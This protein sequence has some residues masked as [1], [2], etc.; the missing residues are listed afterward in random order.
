MKGFAWMQCI[1]WMNYMLYL[2][3]AA[4]EEVKVDGGSYEEHNCHTREQGLHPSD[5]EFKQHFG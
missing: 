4:D 2:L 5:V 1:F 3:M